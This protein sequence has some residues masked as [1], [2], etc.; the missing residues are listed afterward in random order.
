[1][2]A[3]DKFFLRGNAGGGLEQNSFG[4]GSGTH[5]RKSLFHSAQDLFEV[6]HGGFL[7]S[8]F[9][10]LNDVGSGVSMRVEVPEILGVFRIGRVSGFL[11]EDTSVFGIENWE[12]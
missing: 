5:F 10:F 6:R 8:G 3:E 7:R 4:S 1:L 11:F 9:D 12:N 2:T